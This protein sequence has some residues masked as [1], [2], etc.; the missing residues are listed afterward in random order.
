M[1]LKSVL[2]S[3][4]LGLVWVLLTLFLLSDLLSMAQAQTPSRPSYE[5]LGST[6]MG[7][8]EA[9]VG[10]MIAPW[11]EEFA[12]SMDRPPRF[13]DVPYAPVDAQAF[14]EGLRLQEDVR[15]LRQRR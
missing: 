11:K 8:P 12:S 6:V 2:T 4:G 1:S 15:S 5:R 7:D 13:F 3:L 14:V 9:A 10:L